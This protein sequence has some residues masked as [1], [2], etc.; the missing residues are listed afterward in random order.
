MTHRGNPFLEVSTACFFAWEAVTPSSFRRLPLH[1]P[2]S[3]FV[4]L[5]QTRFSLKTLRSLNWTN[6]SCI[7]KKYNEQAPR[8]KQVFAIKHSA[9]VTFWIFC[10]FLRIYISDKC[11]LLIVEN[12]TFNVAH[13]KSGP[14]DLLYLSRRCC[15]L[16]LLHLF[17]Q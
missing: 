7:Y 1:P 5:E 16:S 17:R 12:L 11:N 3:F 13:T 8:S 6:Y 4:I 14:H 15:L 2:N 9:S 10:M